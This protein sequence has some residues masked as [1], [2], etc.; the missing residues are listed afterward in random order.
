VK[1]RPVYEKCFKD[2]D[3]V[4]SGLLFL[5]SVLLKKFRLHCYLPEG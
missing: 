5:L 1:E 2:F 3:D 4:L